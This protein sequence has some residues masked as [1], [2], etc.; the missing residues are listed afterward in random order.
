MLLRLLLASPLLLLLRFLL[1]L[2]LFLFQLVLSLSAYYYAYLLLPRVP[3]TMPPS[4]SVLLL[5]HL[6]LV[7]SYVSSRDQGNHCDWER[8]RVPPFQAAPKKGKPGAALLPER[9]FLCD[10]SPSG[11]LDLYGAK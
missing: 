11:E 4:P 5:L 1:P 7:P 2:L 6:V 9:Q 10:A 3:M 8:S